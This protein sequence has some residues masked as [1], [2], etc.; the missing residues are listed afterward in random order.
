MHTRINGGLS[1]TD[2]K[3]FAVKPRGLPRSSIVV[4]TVTPVMNELSALRYSE[5]LKF[6]SLT[7]IHSQSFK[8]YA[9]ALATPV[10]WFQKNS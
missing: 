5:I 1:Y 9:R 8:I 3:E 4:T 10:D 7:L 6:G 2:V